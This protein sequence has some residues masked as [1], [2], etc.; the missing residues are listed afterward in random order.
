MN[1]PV[2]NRNIWVERM[3]LAAI[4]A[5]A[6]RSLLA[7]SVYY[8]EHNT[9]KA[10]EICI[11]ILR[12]LGLCRNFRSAG[13]VMARDDGTGFSMFQSSLEYIDAA[14]K[15]FTEEALGSESRITTQ[16]IRSYMAQH[17]RDAAAFLVMAKRSALDPSRQQEA[18]SDIFFIVRHPL[19]RILIRVI[20]SYNNIKI[21]EYG[22]TSAMKFYF[23]PWLKIIVVSILRML[24]K[25]CLGN[26]RLGRPSVWVEYPSVDFADFTFWS[27][28]S[29]NEKFDIV[30]YLDRGD[31]GPTEKAASK[32]RARGFRW[33]RF[34]LSDIAVLGRADIRSLFR[35]R[36]RPWRKTPIWVNAFLTEYGLYRILY[37][38]VFK[39]YN[40]KIIIQ[41]QEA[42]W[43]QCAMAEAVSAAGGMMAGFNWSQYYI[44]PL[45]THNFSQH[46][47][48]VWGEEVK[49]CIERI[50]RPAR[51]LPSGVW[52]M[53][54]KI[55][56][57]TLDKLYD[58]GRKFILAIFDNSASYKIIHSQDMLSKFYL[59]MLELLEENPEWGAI[60]KA[61]N[62]NLNGIRTLPGGEKICG[63][64][65]D[66]VAAERLVV[67]DHNYN[68]LAASEYSDICACFGINSAGIISATYGFRAVYWDCGG[69]LKRIDN[70]ECYKEATYQSLKEMTDALRRAAAG[71]A[72]IGGFTKWRRQF[73]YF[74][75]FLASQRVGRFIQDFME[76]VINTNDAERSLDYSVNKYIRENNIKTDMQ[77][78]ILCI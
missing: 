78:E 22:L 35:N 24:S 76:E 19:N 8:D 39:K 7:K 58:G 25:S 64:I 47:Y 73:N 54:Y 9:P 69:V 17:M 11:K 3:T 50:G 59:A 41:H 70:A 5:F 14:I 61:K 72:S 15:R 30:Y 28:Y 75:D 49:R 33:M 44:Y 67:L 46:V 52:T 66:L 42:S 38:S 74:D 13:L 56:P 12:G 65:S 40:V 16:A 68:A 1:I 53:K 57:P 55:R 77:G 45:P 21:R 48:F 71:D 18:N 10:A 63:K 27:P 36:L 2:F 29:D 6:L 4:P 60:I 23:T 51:I 32:I 20:G 43:K 34:Y 31:E 26:A 62:Y 37:E